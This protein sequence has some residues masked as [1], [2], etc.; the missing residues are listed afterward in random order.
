ML[1]TTLVWS[2]NVVSFLDVKEAAL[3]LGVLVLATCGVL[4]NRNPAP[5]FRAL[6]PCWVVL[7]GAVGLGIA[8]A[9]FSSFVWYEGLRLLPLLLLGTLAF[10][11]LQ[12]PA[13]GIAI[14]RSICCAALC[15]AIL[16]LFQGAGAMA[17]VFPRFPHYDQDMYSVFGN[18]GLLA[19]FLAVGL[20]CLPGAI[21]SA[22]SHPRWRTAGLAA[23]MAL[24]SFTI[25]MTGS[26]G[27]LVAAVA[28]MCALLMARAVPPRT[29]IPALLGMLIAVPFAYCFADLDLWSKWRGLFSDADVGGNVRRWILGASLSLLG[30]HP[31]AGCGLGH[32]AREIP[33]WLGHQALLDARGAN[34]LLTDHAH[35]DLLEWLCETGLAGAIGVLW[36][37][38]SLR[39]KSPVALCGLISLAVFSLTHPAFHSAP[40]ALV[41]VALYT[42]NLRNRPEAAACTSRAR[43]LSI[44]V[45]GGA[46]A[47]AAI[48]FATVFYP[49]AVLRRAEDAHLA[50]GDARADYEAATRAW[51]YHPDAHESYGIYAYERGDFSLAREHLM[52]ARPGLETGR[53]YQLLALVATARGDSAGAC[54]WYGACLAR[55][56]W[57]DAIREWLRTNCDAGGAKRMNSG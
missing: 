22:P 26:R 7:A 52:R 29:A 48:F 16:A 32:F 47:G 34:A 39:F 28:G 35:M 12:H 57:N 25:L 49:S 56:P 3:W 2:L 20:V 15:A 38:S 6:G 8:V 1:A 5:G 17:G 11:L 44:G 14:R 53:V 46:M 30:E 37:I 13:H 40:H 36:V 4:F 33:V 24:L 51:G 18:E 21:Q 23:A 54:G 43:G 41:G 55:W 50:G 31:L 19:G 27:A 45:A 9:P 42:M 10:D